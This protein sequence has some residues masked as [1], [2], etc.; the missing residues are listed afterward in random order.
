MGRSA[1]CHYHC[2]RKKKRE[3]GISL[4]FWFRVAEAHNPRN[5][6]SRV[7]SRG[8][9]INLLIIIIR[10]RATLASGPTARTPSGYVC[11]RDLSPASGS[12]RSYLPWVSH[13]HATQPAPKLNSLVTRTTIAICI[14]SQLL[15]DHTQSPA[16]GIDL[17]WRSRNRATNTTHR[18][19]PSLF[20]WQHEKLLSCY[21]HLRLSGF[22]FF[23]V[24]VSLP[25]SSSTTVHRPG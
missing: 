12:P 18:K 15:P 17:Q 2:V 4:L 14:L 20:L 19:P 6:D 25:D 16:D 24:F 5:Q 3:R 10:R 13:E 1:F 23:F 8:D 7:E 9:R 22:K 21:F 11:P